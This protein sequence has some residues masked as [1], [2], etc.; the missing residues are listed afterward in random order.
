[1][2]GG[3]VPPL[4]S[5]EELQEQFLLAHGLDEDEAESDEDGVE[6]DKTLIIELEDDDLSLIS[7]SRLLANVGFVSF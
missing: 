3:G 1:M 2:A 7:C 5:F 4:A 6:N